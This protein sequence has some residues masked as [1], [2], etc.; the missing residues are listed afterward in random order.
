MFGFQR[1]GDLIWLAG[2]IR[3]KGFLIGGTAGRTTLNGEGL[4]HQDGHGHLMATAFPSLIAYDTAFRYEVAVIIQDGL[5]RMYQDQEDVFYYLTVGNENYEMPAMPEN[6]QTGI[7]NGLYRFSTGRALAKSET[8]ASHKV[9]LFG[10]GSIMN[11]CIKAAQILEKDYGLSVDVWGATNYKR[12]RTEAVVSERWN[13]LNPMK[14][15]KSSYV[16]DLL[17]KERGVFVSA[18]DNVRLVAEQ[19]R[20][21]VPGPYVVLGTDGFGRSDTRENLRRFFEVDAE[22]IVVATLY[23]LS[24]DGHLDRHIVADAMKT[25]KIKPD[26][27]YPM[28]SI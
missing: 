21:W 3:C 27:A 15:A 8:P 12:L 10:S 24:Q 23:Q 5:K 2:D 7:L 28:V 1:V 20:K 22:S 11:C 14:P 17:A 4:Q 13:M 26:K 18:S 25:F 16:Q 9:H 19:I 6:A